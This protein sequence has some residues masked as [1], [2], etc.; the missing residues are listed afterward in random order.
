MHMHVGPNRASS[1]SPPPSA[2]RARRHRLGFWA[3]SVSLSL[4]LSLS[5][6]LCLSVCLSLGLPLPLSLSLSLCPPP[7]SLVWVPWPQSTLPAG[8]LPHHRLFGASL[9][10]DKK[11]APSQPG[12]A[13][14]PCHSLPRP[15]PG[16]GSRPSRGLAAHQGVRWGCGT[17]GASCAG[18]AEG[19]AVVVK[20][21]RRNVSGTR[22]SVQRVCPEHRLCSQPWAQ[23]SRC[24]VPDLYQTLSPWGS[25][26]SGRLALIKSL[27]I[28]VF[29][30][31]WIRA[32][33][34]NI[35]QLVG[36]RELSWK[37]PL[38]R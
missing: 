25:W 2:G 26:S 30:C 6:C 37:A 13:P 22:A 18:E 1:K 3:V 38:R 27:W 36:L 16:R 10:R 9:N 28:L 8:T 33:S 34:A 19:L 11:P 7:L 17:G 31:K 24:H 20:R 29:Q 32:V 23:P 21:E 5:P 12:T 14:R 4:L 15:S 35:A